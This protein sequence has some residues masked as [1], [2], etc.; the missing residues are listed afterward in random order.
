[1]KTLHGLVN[2]GGSGV[3]GRRFPRWRCRCGAPAPIVF[4]WSPGE[5]LGSGLPDRMT[6]LCPGQHYFLGGVILETQKEWLLLLRVLVVLCFGGGCAARLEPMVVCF[7]LSG[8]PSSGLGHLDVLAQ[9]PPVVAVAVWELRA[10]GGV[11][12]HL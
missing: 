2:S 12:A 8:G 7:S 10:L 5:N 6:V 1:M 9:D 4:W 11:T 3:Y